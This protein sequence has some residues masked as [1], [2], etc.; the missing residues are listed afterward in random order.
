MEITYVI[1]ILVLNTPIFF[2]SKE[3][4]PTKEACTYALYLPQTMEDTQRVANYTMREVRTF[5]APTNLLS[6]D[7]LGDQ[8]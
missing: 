8:I 2:T 1:V 4:Y 7:T 6:D 3:E 5:C